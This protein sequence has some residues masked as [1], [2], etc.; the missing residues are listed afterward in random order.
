MRLFCR[1]TVLVLSVKLYVIC[2]GML[3]YHLYIL[4]FLSNNVSTYV[5]FWGL[6]FKRHVTYIFAFAFVQRS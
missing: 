5:L 6:V 1:P 4:R 2:F 3:E